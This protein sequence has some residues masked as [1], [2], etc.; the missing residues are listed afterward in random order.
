MTILQITSLLVV[1]AGVFGSVNYFFLRLPPSIGILVVALAASTMAMVLDWL[2]P[3]IGIAD[4]VRAVVL[5]IEF[6]TALLD[7][8]LGLLLFAGALHVRADLLREQALPVA[9]IT[10][11]GVLVSTAVAGIGFAWITGFPLVVAMVFGAL[12]SPTDP[13]AVLGVLR[14]AKLRKSLEIQIAG[15]SLF[16][17]GVGYV[18]F[19]L[20]VGLAFP[21]QGEHHAEGWQ[22]VATLFLREAVGGAALGG[23]LGWLTF[24]LIRHI[25]DYALEVLISLGLALGGYELAVA[26]GVSGPIMAVI[27]GLFIGD[28]GKKFGMGAITQ[29]YLDKFWE[30]IDEMLNAVLFLLI[31]VEV[32]ALALDLD[33]I[34]AGVLAIGLSLLAR[35]VGV[36]AP[37]LLLRSW[38]PQKRDVIPIMTW[39]GLKGGISVALALSLPDSEWK[40]TILAATYFVVVFSIIVQGLSI[41]LLARWLK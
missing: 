37:V 14:E 7:W 40:P 39:G 32:F 23:V 31:G 8:M 38:E 2:A 19:L 41:G 21:L 27:A 16:N 10:L 3:G 15:E 24:Q 22:S 9:V 6:S 36:A 12:I 18:V 4:A 28:V 20:L 35:L 5:D 13:V 26:I 25:D 30:I 17:D 29:E 1:L 11:V 33:M 34:R